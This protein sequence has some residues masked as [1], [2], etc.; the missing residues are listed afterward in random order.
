MFQR[1]KQGSRKREKSG[2]GRQGWGRR[3]KEKE[4]KMENQTEK[5]RK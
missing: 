2:E 3:G 4:V 5:E 1:R